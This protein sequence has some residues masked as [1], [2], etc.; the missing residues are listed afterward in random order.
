MVFIGSYSP[1]L[2]A[3][4]SAVAWVIGLAL[5]LAALWLG[6][7]VAVLGAVGLIA[8]FMGV[9]NAAEALAVLAG[10]TMLTIITM[11]AT[12]RF[13]SHIPTTPST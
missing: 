3:V 6:S 1:V 2:G 12:G 9:S 13:A 10:L 7:L 5:V 4:V 8:G 11:Y